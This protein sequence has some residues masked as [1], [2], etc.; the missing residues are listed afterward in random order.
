MQTHYK[1]LTDLQWEIIKKKL[2]IQRK[3]KYDL[4]E[5]VDG[6]FWISRTG[7]QWRNLPEIFPKWQL[8]YYYFRKWATDGTL[9]ALNCTLNTLFRKQSGKESTPSAVSI[10]SQSIKKAPFVNKQTGIDGNKKVNGRKRHILTD[11]MGLVWV[12]ISH[13]ANLHD[14]VMAEKVVAPVLGY[15]H[16]LRKVYA[17]MAYKVD[18]GN[19]LDNMYTSI[20]LEISSRPESTKGFVPVKIRWVTEQ[21]FGIFNF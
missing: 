1:K 10:D 15:L 14:W 3:R 20:E 12:S 19:W 11:T 13:A 17:D 6:I 2:P 4:R 18:L 8:V 5:I 7:S 21:T 16:R 9:F